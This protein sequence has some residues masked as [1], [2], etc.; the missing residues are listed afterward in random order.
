MKNKLIDIVTLGSSLIFLSALLSTTVSKFGFTDWL[1]LVIVILGGGLVA[2]FLRSLNGQKII[3]DYLDARG[4]VLLFVNL[5]ILIICGTLPIIE[6]MSA[7][8]R[9]VIFLIGYLIV[10]MITYFFGSETA[11][12]KM[13][14]PKL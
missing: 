14:W 10:W 2:E 7:G 3:W 8:V 1:I 11:K 12:E 13:L 5:V 6:E 4:K 9:F